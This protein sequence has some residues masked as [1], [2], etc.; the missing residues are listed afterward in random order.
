MTGE[1]N[2]RFG[3]IPALLELSEDGLHGFRM[4]ELTEL[5]VSDSSRD[6]SDIHNRKRLN[7]REARA[8]GWSTVPS[9]VPF[10]YLHGSGGGM[11][12]ELERNVHD[13]SWPLAPFPDVLAQQPHLMPVGEDGKG[14]ELVRL[15]ENEAHNDHA[16]NKKVKVESMHG[17]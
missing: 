12:Q 11:A 13:E 6:W 3:E 9:W 5:V 17:L 1:V 8:E 4:Q 7:Q 14:K 2:R 10:Q 16:R 15:D